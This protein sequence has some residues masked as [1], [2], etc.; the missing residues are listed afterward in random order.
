MVPGLVWELPAYLQPHLSPQHP[1]QP[2]K[3]RR[4]PLQHQYAM[5]GCRLCLK[6]DSITACPV[7]QNADVIQ[8]ICQ[9]HCI[10]APGGGSFG[11]EPLSII[12]NLADELSGLCGQ[13][14]QEDEDVLWERSPGAQD[15]I[16]V[17][18]GHCHS[19]RTHTTMTD[20]L[21]TKAP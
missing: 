1:P 17:L 4:P 12:T 13:R 15:A 11:L 9:A 19:K 10:T 14:K 7:S 3:V 18:P 2:R 5:S 8:S 16:R 21:P 6:L 20:P